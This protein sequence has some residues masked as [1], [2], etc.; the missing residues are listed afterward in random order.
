MKIEEARM[1]K[2]GAV[3]NGFVAGIK[4]QFYFSI[5]FSEKNCVVRYDDDMDVIFE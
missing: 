2:N 3:L 1:D 4:K 5:F